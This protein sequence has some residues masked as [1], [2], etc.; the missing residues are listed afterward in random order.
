MRW[1]RMGLGR[2]TGVATKVRPPKGVKQ[3]LTH[4]TRTQTSLAVLIMLHGSPRLSVS[5]MQ[6]CMT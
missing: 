5:K 3:P 1:P 6:Q 4:Q 2:L